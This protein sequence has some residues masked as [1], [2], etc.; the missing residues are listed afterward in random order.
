MIGFGNNPAWFVPLPGQP[1][2]TFTTACTGRTCQ[3]NAAGS[4]DP[5]GTIVSLRV[6]VRGWHHRLRASTGAHVLERQ[7]LWRDPDRH[8]Q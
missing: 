7:H 4:F 6:E 8:R 1:T 2:A 3:F 5:D